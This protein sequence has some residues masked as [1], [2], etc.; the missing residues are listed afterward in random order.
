MTELIFQIRLKQI[1]RKFR[2]LY[3]ELAIVELCQNKNLICAIE[4]LE[5]QLKGLIKND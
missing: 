3:G 2:E 5:T 4:K 1:R